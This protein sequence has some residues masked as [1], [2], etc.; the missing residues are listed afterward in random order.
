MVYYGVSL[1]FRTWPT[2]SNCFGA[3]LA[4]TQRCSEDFVDPAGHRD[5]SSPEGPKNS[6]PLEMASERKRHHSNGGFLGSKLASLESRVWCGRIVSTPQESHYEWLYDMI[7]VFSS[8]LCISN[9]YIQKIS[10]GMFSYANLGRLVSICC[11]WKKSY[12]LRLAHILVMDFPSVSIFLCPLLQSPPLRNFSQALGWKQT[13]DDRLGP[14]QTNKAHINH[15][16]SVST[17]F[18]WIF[19]SIGFRFNVQIHL[20]QSK[21]YRSF[22]VSIQIQIVKS[23]Q[24]ASRSHH[25]YISRAQALPK[26]IFEVPHISEMRAQGQG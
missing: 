2:K 5:G 7:Y 26:E 21:I 4:A 11:F 16:E 10:K 6:E 25:R 18:I 17:R 15:I 22:K 19:Q 13:L 24:I 23:E 3:G 9:G 20:F 14:V 12:R 1:F 8:F